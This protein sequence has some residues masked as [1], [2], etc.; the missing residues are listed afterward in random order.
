MY[1]LLSLMHTR[2]R[3][4][5]ECLREL[6]DHSMYLCPLCM[7]S[8]MAP[9]SMERLWHEMDTAVQQTPMPEE[10]RGMRVAIMVG[11]LSEQTFS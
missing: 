2:T 1:S 10:Y 3:V 7:K 11:A 6:A 9:S 4:L 8:Y 5:Q